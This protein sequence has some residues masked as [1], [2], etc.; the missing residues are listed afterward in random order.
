MMREILDYGA[1]I[2]SVI[3]ITIMTFVF[4]TALIDRMTIETR[5]R[6][7]VVFI[8]LIITTMML[9]DLTNLGDPT[10]TALQNG[11]SV[12]LGI[13]IGVFAAWFFFHEL[14]DKLL[15]QRVPPRAERKENSEKG[16]RSRQRRSP[17]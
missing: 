2:V 1:R 7:Y 10:K 16:R 9:I 17:N 5:M 11:L 8:V 12:G 4:F 6:G 3:L 15:S 13:S 14:F